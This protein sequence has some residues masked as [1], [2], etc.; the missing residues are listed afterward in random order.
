[1]Q[2]LQNVVETPCQASLDAWPFGA[3]AIIDYAPQYKEDFKR[4]NL[5]WIAYYF[6]VED[7]DNALLSDPE[8]YFLRPGGY[9]FFAQCCEQ[10]VGTCALLK[11]PER[12]FELSKM[13]VTRP[14]RGMHIGRTLV[15]TALEKVRA[16]GEPESFLETHSK[17][18]PAMHLYKKFGFRQKPFP[19]GRSERYQ[20]ANTYMV[21]AL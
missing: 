21:S 17:L 10:I 13:G 19:H 2:T 7:I 14:Y 1:M 4:L 16:L 20:R 5:E 18:L 3:I 9:I 11:H 15:E 6:S 12:G 8:K